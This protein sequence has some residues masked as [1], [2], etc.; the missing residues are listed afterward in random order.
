MDEVIGFLESL[1]TRIGTTVEALWPNAVRHV[2]IEGL[3]SVV[4]AAVLLVVIL[5]IRFYYRKQEWFANYASEGHSADYGPSA[6]FILTIVVG[7]LILVTVL[8]SCDN[9]AKVLEPEGHLVREI[10]RK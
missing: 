5:G 6:K 7:I 10:L 4:A 9:M 3:S 8:A 1:A 2:A